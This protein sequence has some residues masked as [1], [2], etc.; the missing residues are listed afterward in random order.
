MGERAWDK[1]GCEWEVGVGEGVRERE[2][3]RI[4]EES[5]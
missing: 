4:I 5:C 2:R 1:K 3:E